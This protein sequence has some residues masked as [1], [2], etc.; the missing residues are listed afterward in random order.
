MLG[1]VAKVIRCTISVE[2]APCRV[3]M[4]GMELEEK[5]E[6]EYLRSPALKTAEM[7]AEMIHRLKERPRM[8]L[9]LEKQ[10]FAHGCQS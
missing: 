7:K 1:R 8:T 3:I 9:R 2:Q 4:D 5:K 10:E 6:F